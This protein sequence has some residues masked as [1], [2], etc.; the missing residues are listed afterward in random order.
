LSYGRP[1]IT[2]ARYKNGD[3][4]LPSQRAEVANFAEDRFPIAYSE[5]VRDARCNR[6]D[7][8]IIAADLATRPSWQ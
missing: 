6:A 2:E 7:A 3:V 5:D 1:A 4:V 8:L